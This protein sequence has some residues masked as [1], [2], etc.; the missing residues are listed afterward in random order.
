M[1]KRSVRHGEPAWASLAYILW[2]R[3]HRSYGQVVEHLAGEGWYVTHADV[4]DV[5]VTRAGR[6][7]E[8]FSRRRRPR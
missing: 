7:L 6:E 3:G 8:A 1:A 4:E 5:C 2:R